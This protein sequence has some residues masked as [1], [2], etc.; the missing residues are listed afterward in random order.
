M[1]NISFAPIWSTNNQHFI[2]Y[3]NCHIKTFPDYL[4]TQLVSVPS[5]CRGS[6][7]WVTWTAS[8]TTACLVWRQSPLTRTNT[9]LDLKELQ[10]SVTATPSTASINSL[11]L[12]IGPVD[13]T[14]H[15]VSVARV[16]VSP[17]LFPFMEV[18]RTN[19]SIECCTD[20]NH[21][22]TNLR[23]HNDWF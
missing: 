14:W 22:P 12:P 21:Q 13:S 4:F 19:L 6:R 11:R 16:L 23:N 17:T 15:R 18:I 10:S 2:Q 1:I 8:G 20:D 9:A 5:C 3:F 7:N